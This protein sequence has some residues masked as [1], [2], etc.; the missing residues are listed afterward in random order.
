[1]SEG[2]CWKCKK[3]LTEIE[4]KFYGYGST[5]W[6]HCHHEP[7]EK[8]KCWCEK[9]GTRAFPQ[10]FYLECQNGILNFCPQCGEKLIESPIR[11]PEDLRGEIKVHP[12]SGNF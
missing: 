2:L 5:I 11:A 7:K 1:M 6:W 4:K 10:C 8:P 3:E 9:I 12:K